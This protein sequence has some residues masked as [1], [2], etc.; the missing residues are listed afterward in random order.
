M[1]NEN[2][3]NSHREVDAGFKKFGGRLEEWIPSDPLLHA[4]WIFRNKKNKE[5]QF[6]YEVKIREY[7]LLPTPMSWFTMAVSPAGL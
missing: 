4:I 1:E 3:N 7:I 6:I 2:A 5:C